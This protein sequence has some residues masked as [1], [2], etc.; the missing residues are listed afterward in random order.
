M[1]L[2]L[3]IAACSGLWAARDLATRIDEAVTA[4]AGDTNKFMGSVPV[5]RDGKVILSRGYGFANLEWEIPNTADTKF[6]L[7]SD[8][9]TIHHVLSHTAGIPSFTSFPEY[10]MGP[11]GM[12]DSGYGLVIRAGKH[13]SIGHGGGIEG[14]HTQLTYFPDDKAVVVVLGNVNGMAPAQI[15]NR[16]GELAL[17]P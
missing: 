1:K 15:A 4:V 13:K 11:A 10:V 2:V 12:N 7:G 14:F 9:I 6:R 3:L 8:K 16:L 17:E 5:A